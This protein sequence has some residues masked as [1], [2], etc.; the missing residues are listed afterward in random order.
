LSYML[1]FRAVVMATL[2]GTL[3]LVGS[4]GIQASQE[5]CQIKAQNSEAQA[6][7]KFAVTKQL[8]DS[9]DGMPDTQKDSIANLAADTISSKKVESN[10]GYIGHA[11]ATL[12]DMIKAMFGVYC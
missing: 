11:F 8:H 5:I 6:Y 2:M 7:T 10:Y 12:G 3:V 4:L 9:L 1:G